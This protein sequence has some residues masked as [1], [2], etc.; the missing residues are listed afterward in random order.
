[1]SG[2]NSG[3]LD[4]PPGITKENTKFAVGKR[5]F[6]GNFVRWVDGLLVPVGGWLTYQTL[7]SVTQPIRAMFSWVDNSVQAWLAAGAADR[8]T[9]IKAGSVPV[10]LDITPPTLSWSPGYQVGYGGGAYGKKAYSKDSLTG[11]VTP[12]P[13]SLWSFD[14]FGQDLYAVHSQDGRLF[15]WSPTDPVNYVLQSSTPNVSPWNSANL[16]ITLN[17]VTGPDGVSFIGNKIQAIAAISTSFSQFGIIANS[18]VVT[19][20]IYAKQGSGPTV[21]NVFGVYNLTTST[22]LYFVSVNFATGVASLYAGVGSA[23]VTNEGNGWWR[24]ALTVSAGVTVGDSLIV[25]DGYVGGTPTAGEYHYSCRAQLQNGPVATAYAATITAPR[26][27]GLVQVSGAP[28]D[29][30][31]VVVTDERFIMTFGGLNHPRRVKWCSRENPSDW[32]AIETNS[33][34]GFELDSSAAIVAVAKILGGIIVFTDQDVHI[35]EYVGAPYWYNHRLLTNHTGIISQY[36]H[37]VTPNGVIWMGASGFWRYDGAVTPLPCSVQNEVY[38]NSYLG[39]KVSVF[40]SN[41]EAFQEVWAF[42]P[43]LA[44]TEATRY[45]MFSYRSQPFWSLGQLTRTAMVN[46]VYQTKPYMAASNV[47]YEH[48]SG[49]TANGA[50]RSVYAT[51]GFISLGA[52]EAKMRS[53][54]V[55]ADAKVGNALSEWEY[56]TP[57]PFSLSFEL[58]EAP[59]SA[60]RTYG[61]VT[62]NSQKGYNTVRFRSRLVSITVTEAIQQSWGMGKVVMRSKSAGKR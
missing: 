25:Y 32:T 62:F 42:Y 49:W 7:A 21:S 14:N 41:N 10:Q 9:V 56:P 47:I 60:A 58:R 43:D 24:L 51:T 23:I 20:S 4:I 5:W 11:G 31:L 13:D 38:K 30:R 15:S 19:Y 50:A 3:I 55:Y 53:D 26:G 8:C 36:A 1:M 16:T 17:S 39:K 33:A 29:N 45:A 34:G 57:F 12:D 44:S 46:P 6:G 28:T 22:S 18:N 2:N 27:I 61:P 35:I 37:A 48:E 54:R 52:G 40:L 59:K